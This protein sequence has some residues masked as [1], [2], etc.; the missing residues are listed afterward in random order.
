MFTTDT[1]A[2]AKPYEKPYDVPTVNYNPM[3][4]DMTNVN[5]DTLDDET[6]AVL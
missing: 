6:L 2:E 3:D 5:F 1:S 4:Y